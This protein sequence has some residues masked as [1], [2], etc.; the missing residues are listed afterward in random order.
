MLIVA[1]KQKR[2]KT[3]PP[4][5]SESVEQQHLFTWAAFYTGKYP[6]LELLH[7]IPNGGSRTKSEAGRFKAEGVKAGVPDVCLPVARNGW[8]GLYIE[9]KKQGGTVSKEQSKWLH[10]LLQQGYLTAVCYGWEVAAQIIKDY[11]DGKTQPKEPTRG[12]TVQFTCNCGR[13]FEKPESECKTN[14]PNCYGTYF[15]WADC[16]S[17]G[18]TCQ[19]VRNEGKR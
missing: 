15:A 7:H 3:A 19:A 8:H 13:T 18:K 2:E 6:E 17:C 11:L 4:A 16:P 10:S 5:P 9:M 1:G 12:D 14:V